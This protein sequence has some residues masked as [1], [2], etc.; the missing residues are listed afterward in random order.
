M[1]RDPFAVFVALALI[2]WVSVWLEEN[3]RAVRYAGS[4]LTAILVATILANFGMLPSSSPAYD[5]LGGLG[6]SVG[7]ALVLMG[8]DVKSVIRAGPKM[9]AAFGLGATGTAV[10]AIVGGLVLSG[11]VGPETWK[12]AGQYTG[13]YTGGSV[14]F[15][16]VGR[17]VETSPDLYSAA[18]A[19]RLGITRQAAHVRHA[20]AL[21]DLEK[22][23]R[24]LV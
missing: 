18:I 12:L 3:V 14:N 17:A 19:A 15:V 22:P 6:V 13:T 11:A 21:R 1:I 16:A 9:L 10:G 5:M 24:A 23:L 20:A 7:I 8:V 2:V 4:V